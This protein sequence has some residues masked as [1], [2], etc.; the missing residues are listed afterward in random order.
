M[1]AARNGMPWT[2]VKDTASTRYSARSRPAELAQ[3]DLGY[4]HPPVPAEDARRGRPGSGLRWTRW[5]WAT[6]WPRAL[7]RCTPAAMAP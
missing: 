2:W 4:Q 5:A 3:V 7:T 1:A 6:W